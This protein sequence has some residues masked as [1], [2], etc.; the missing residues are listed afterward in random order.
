MSKTVSN[1]AHVIDT[2]LAFA[3][4]NTSAYVHGIPSS[5]SC[6]NKYLCPSRSGIGSD[7]MEKMEKHDSKTF[8]DIAKREFKT[9]FG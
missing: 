7:I 2:S 4:K 3:A 8:Q 9:E 1:R 6:F 5:P